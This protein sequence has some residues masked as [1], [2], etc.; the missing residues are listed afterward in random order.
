MQAGRAIVADDYFYRLR[1]INSPNM[2]EE[3]RRNLLDDLKIM[4]GGEKKDLLSEEPDRSGLKGLK[5]ELERHKK[6]E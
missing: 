3:E 1:I 5:Q 2:N 4:A 6:K